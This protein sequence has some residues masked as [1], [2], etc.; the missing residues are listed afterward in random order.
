MFYT[1]LPIIERLP[2]KD[3]DK[4]YEIVQNPLSIIIFKADYFYN[5]LFLIQGIYI[6]YFYLFKKKNYYISYI[7]FEIIYKIIP[8]YVLILVSYFFFVNSD[9]FLN[10]PLSKYFYQKEHA[11]CE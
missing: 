1:C 9:I 7:I 8:I 5:I 10:N 6:S 4:F 2:F 11:N 3:P